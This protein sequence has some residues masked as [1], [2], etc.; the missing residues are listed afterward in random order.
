MPESL[1]ISSSDF[2]KVFFCTIGYIV[3]VL[4]LIFILNFW[5]VKNY[6]TNYGTMSDKRND[7]V[8]I[9]D[10]PDHIQICNL[11]SSHG[12]YSFDYSVLHD[13]YVCFNFGLPAQSL[14]Y[15]YRI[16]ET[17]SDKICTGAKVF[18]VLSHFSFFGEDE[19]T[20][21]TFRSKNQRYYEFLPKE[22][23]KQYN[24]KDALLSKYPVFDAN[25]V[26]DLSMVLLGKYTIGDK[27]HSVT[28][29]EKEAAYAPE[30]AK[31]FILDR[32]DSGGKRV[33]NT[34]EIEA[35]YQIIDLCKERGFVPYLITTPYLQEYNDSIPN[36]DDTF[37]SEFYELVNQVCSSTGVKYYDFSS[38]SMFS[39]S[40]ELF[41][42]ADHLNKQGAELF[43]RM[44]IQKAGS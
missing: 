24:W 15:D 34:T 7:S 36:I 5:Y 44:V 6:P 17:Y 19:T 35:L 22:A 29:K 3:S 13:E 11:G 8:V 16:L 25:S 42:N 27:W 14:S 28:D 33:Y 1:Y 4:L 41:R 39:T 18:I 9:K 23:I 20:S 43:T 26:W 38:D 2:K 21:D 32:K 37:L 10:V 40:Y 12:L 31:A 30:R